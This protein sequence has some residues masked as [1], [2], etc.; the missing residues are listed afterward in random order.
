MAITYP[1]FEAFAQ[2]VQDAWAENPDWFRLNGQKTAGDRHAWGYF[3]H[4]GRKWTVDAD[5]AFLPVKVAYE[6]YTETSEWP[7]VI[8]KA[9]VRDCLVLIPAVRK[10]LL[11][12]N[13]DFEKYKY[14]YL[15]SPS[16]KLSRVK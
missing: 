16:K 11:Q 13:S 15:Y 3:M 2:A 8:E 5:T 14:Y 12:Q 10:K 4:K 1:D 7:F 6:H 9:N